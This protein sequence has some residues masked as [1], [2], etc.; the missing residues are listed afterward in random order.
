VGHLA[1]EGAKVVVADVRDAAVEAMVAAHG[2]TAVGVDEIHRVPCDIL[3]PSALGATLNARTIPELRCAA[4]CGCANN[5]LAEPADAERLAA[6]GV[7]YAPD[8]VVN[9]GGVI[10]IAEELRGYDRDRA[11]E[12]IRGI[13]ATTTLVLETAAQL[14]ITTEAAAEHVAEERLT[15]ASTR[16]RHDTAR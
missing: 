11:Y 9:A 1:A 2:A 13:G 4:V 5:Q 3:S 7:L 14:G 15:K 16:E 8:F 10:N 6:A 12:R